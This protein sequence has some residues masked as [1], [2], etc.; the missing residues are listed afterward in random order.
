[1]HTGGMFTEQRGE[2]R[3]AVALPLK[4]GD[5]SA[6]VTRDI[7]PSGMYL[8]IHGNP[9][10]GGTLLFEM[11]LQDVHMKFT[12]E[13]RVVRLERC[14]GFTGIAVRLHSPRL[15]PLA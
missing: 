13:G 4:L 10:L 11:D 9:D 1:M 14:D 5:G 7:S 3:E 6:A 2:P 15:E 12:A 8:Q